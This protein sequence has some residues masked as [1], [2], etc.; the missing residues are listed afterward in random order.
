M[1]SVG[2]RAIFVHS[3]AK[4]QKDNIGKAELVAL[5]RPAAE[6]LA[7]DDEMIGRV[8]ASR[9]LLEVHCDEKTVP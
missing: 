9:V 6:L 1:F 5:K 4:S 2:V 8:I 7:Y 3:F